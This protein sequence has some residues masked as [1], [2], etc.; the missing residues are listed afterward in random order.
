MKKIFWFWIITSSLLLLTVVLIP[1]EIS[2]KITREDGIIEN[3]SALSYLLSSIIFFVL[4]LKRK[5]ILF[6]LVWMVCTLIFLGEET[7]WG[8]RI[9]NYE[10][11]SIQDKNL[12]NEVNIHNLEYFKSPKSHEI[13]SWR[14]ILLS[15]QNL[16]RIAFFTYFLVFPLFYFLVKRRYTF[17]LLPS[18]FYWGV[19]ILFSISI[20]LKLLSDVNTGLPLAETREFLYA[21]TILIYSLCMYLR[22]TSDIIPP[23]QSP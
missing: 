18:F 1:Q 17:A 7:S 4:V 10:I 5:N 16:F 20:V 23:S 22:K 15:S 6:Y 13:S 14:D 21:F 12:Q 3:L 8:Q 11:S 9:F 19:F 2:S